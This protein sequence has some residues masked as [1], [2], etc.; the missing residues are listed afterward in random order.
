[1]VCASPAY[2]SVHGRPARPN[3]L[4]KH[5]CIVFEGLTS[6]AA[7]RFRVRKR[8]IEVAIRPRLIVNTAEAAIDAAI[9]G[10]GVTCVLS[11]QIAEAKRAG[12]L[13]IVLERFEPE[14]LPV[15]LVYGGHGFLPQKTRAFIDLA[16][17]R[18]RMTLSARGALSAPR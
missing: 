5:D 2:L 17:R 13:S 8:D 15:S 3:D 10:L 4:R 11:Y 12:A 18:L 14:A 16:A 9:S 6:L 1:V 7:W